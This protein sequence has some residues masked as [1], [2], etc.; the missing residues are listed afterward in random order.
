MGIFRLFTLIAF[1]LNAILIT[2][3]QSRSGS[4][5]TCNHT[6]SNEVHQPEHSSSSKKISNCHHSSQGKTH[7]CVC[8]REKSH[9][10]FHFLQKQTL[11]LVPYFTWVPSKIVEYT[12]WE[13]S[14]KLANLHPFPL[15]KPPKNSLNLFPI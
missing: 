1:L 4:F 15:L 5:C 3:I 11:Q 10:R 12:S 6:S 8:K 7:I 14:Y 2:P 13:N 9:S